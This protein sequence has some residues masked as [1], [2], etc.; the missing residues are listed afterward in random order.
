MMDSDEERSAIVAEISSMA[1]PSVPIIPSTRPILAKHTG[2]VDEENYP[3]YISNECFQSHQQQSEINEQQEE[4]QSE[5]GCDKTLDFLDNDVAWIPIQQSYSTKDSYY[6][7]RRRVDFNPRNMDNSSWSVTRGM[8]ADHR[9]HDH[10]WN[11]NNVYRGHR[12]N[13]HRANQRRDTGH[14]NGSLHQKQQIIETQ[15]LKPGTCNKSED[16]TFRF[17]GL[18]DSERP[19]HLEN[20]PHHDM[21]WIAGKTVSTKEEALYPS[22]DEKDP[23]W[24]LYESGYFKVGDRIRFALTKEGRECINQY[25]DLY[26]EP[27]PAEGTGCIMLSERDRSGWGPHGYVTHTHECNYCVRTDPDHEGRHTRFDLVPGL[28]DVERIDS[29]SPCSL[30]QLFHIKSIPETELMAW[31]LKNILGDEHD[32]LTV[33]I[34][35]EYLPLSYQRDVYLNAPRFERLIESIYHPRNGISDETKDDG[36]ITE[37]AIALNRCIPEEVVDM[38]GFRRNNYFNYRRDYE[39]QREEEEGWRD[40]LAYYHEKVFDIARRGHPTFPQNPENTNKK[41]KILTPRHRMYAQNPYLPL[42]TPHGRNNAGI[43]AKRIDIALKPSTSLYGYQLHTVMWCHEVERSI[44]AKQSLCVG[45]ND[46]RFCFDTTS[47]CGVYCVKDENATRLKP[48]VTKKKQKKK[49]KRKSWSEKEI[50]QREAEYRKKHKPKPIYDDHRD[51]MYI[52]A[53]TPR[54][55]PPRIITYK[56][57]VV[58]DDVGLGKTLTMLSL[59]AAHPL[60]DDITRNS[61]HPETGELEYGPDGETILCAATLVLAPSHLIEQ[62]KGEIEQHFK[63]KLLN[64]IMITT[65]ADHKQLTYRDVLEAQVVLVSKSFLSGTHYNTLNRNLI[66]EHWESVD[67]SLPPKPADVSNSRP[68]RHSSRRS[69]R[70]K[71]LQQQKYQDL[72]IKSPFLDL[73]HWRR[74]VVD[75]GHELLPDNK[76]RSNLLRIS[77]EFRWYCTATPFPTDLS[78]EHAAEYLD[79]R[80]NDKIIEWSKELNKPLG[81]VLHNVLYHHLYSK[82]TKESIMTDN[83]LPDV[84]ETS[85][86]INFHPVERVLYD[87]IKKYRNTPL[88]DPALERRMCNGD[89]TTFERGLYLNWEDKQTLKQWCHQHCESDHPERTA[90]PWDDQED[91]LNPVFWDNYLQKL[92]MINRYW[93]QNMI[94]AFRAQIRQ[95]HKDIDGLKLLQQQYRNGTVPPQP[96]SYSLW[97]YS[98]DTH[99]D[100]V[101]LEDIPKEL[102]EHKQKINRLEMELEFYH[103]IHEMI[104]DTK[105]D[106]TVIEFENNIKSEKNGEVILRVLRKYGSKQALLLHFVQTTLE[107]PNNR[108]IIFSLFGVMLETIRERLRD[109]RIEAGLCRGSVHQRRKAMRAFQG[110]SEAEGNR[111]ILLSSKDAAS[112]ADLKLATHVILVDPVPGSAS[113]SFAAE[114]Q[115]IGRAVRQGMDERGIATK[116]LRLVIRDTIEQQ[117]H[118]RNARM[119]EQATNDEEKSRVERENMKWKLSHSLKMEDRTQDEIDFYVNINECAVGKMRPSPP[120]P[121]I[122]DNDSRGLSIIATKNKRRRNDKEEMDASDDDEKEPPKKKV[123]KTSRRKM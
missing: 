56:G 111:V 31:T 19:Y 71:P 88:N 75:E 99:S 74:V 63:N 101:A 89:L 48:T 117:T 77:S 26:N 21:I 47:N 83:H 97:G 46:L 90:Y 113:E 86:M 76:L 87:I 7:K 94:E 68:K 27:L 17:Y 79:I 73:F 61:F 45:S 93:F 51:Y 108:I 64:V 41:T 72:S 110:D 44:L 104:H 85:K 50:E 67:P 123:K 92:L 10:H 36:D 52:S 9:R 98:N 81:S 12:D 58:A 38:K 11:H 59:M 33:N 42:I 116:V 18:L 6:N 40:D 4:K 35:A 53:H 96:R 78:V 30:K 2:P 84:E 121:I 100:I 82:H 8:Y 57:G 95:H 66:D 115:A 28:Y 49:K 106:D 23:L 107:D 22:I 25:R 29:V 43:V 54:V 37:M 62:W 80:L 32:W 39:D 105:I 34:I 13:H 3:V 1:V 114:R 112:G 24:K 60:G 20:Q 70:S 118:D 91:A 109:V 15:L 55:I 14:F 16:D 102:Q 120:K 122:V 65:G 103:P 5:S 119:R 69:S